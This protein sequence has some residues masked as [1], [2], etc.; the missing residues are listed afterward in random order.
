MADFEP[1]HSG[2]AVEQTGV[3]DN[4]DGTVTIIYATVFRKGLTYIY[5]GQPNHEKTS[6]DHVDLS[7]R[8][9]DHR[10]P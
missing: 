6:P 7:N 10:H 4:G 3:K 5:D 2:L 1:W 9:P 8:P